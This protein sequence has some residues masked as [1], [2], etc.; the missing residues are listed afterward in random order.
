MAAL[1]GP[2][3]V[4]VLI[5][6]GLLEVGVR[7]GL[8]TTRVPALSWVALKVGALS[9]GGG[10]VIIPLTQADAVDRYCWMTGAQFLNAV[11]LGQITPGPVVRSG[12]GPGG[13]AG[14]LRRQTVMPSAPATAPVR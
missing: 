3:L 11:A 13:P 10:F 5:G 1:F 6:S 8:S 7:G 14:R 9:H 2:W 4:L 12:G